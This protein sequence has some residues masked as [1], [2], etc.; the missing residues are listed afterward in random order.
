MTLSVRCVGAAEVQSCVEPLADILVDCVEGGASVSFMAPIARA[1]ARGFW[2]GV[3]AAVVEGRC[4]LLLAEADGVVV[5][6]V[7]VVPAAQENQPH[8]ADLAKMLVHRRARN[9][10]VGEALLLAAEAAA[11]TVGRTLLVLDTATGGAGE[12]LYARLG[13]Q[14]VG[15]IPGYAL[16]PD[17]EPCDTTLFCKTLQPMPGSR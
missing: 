13:W 10:G 7:S 15:I 12:R 9:T 5:G 1:T 2:Q 8:R 11:R 6:T 4:I 17:G 14:R 16:Y 3:A